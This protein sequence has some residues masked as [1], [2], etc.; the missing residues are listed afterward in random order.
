MLD[1]VAVAAVDAKLVTGTTLRMFNSDS[2][3]ETGK[4]DILSPMAKPVGS[5][6]RLLAFG[7]RGT[8]LLY[9]DWKTGYLHWLPLTLTEKDKKALAKAY[10]VRNRG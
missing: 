6:C 3:V 2:L 8:K 10:P 9:Y 1:L 7:D 5:A 4:F